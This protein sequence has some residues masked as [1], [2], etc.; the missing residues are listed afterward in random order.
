M[1]MKTGF[2]CMSCRFFLL[3]L[4]GLGFVWLT[5]CCR[6]HHLNHHAIFGAGYRS[7]AVSIMQ[8]LIKKYGQ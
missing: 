6:Y 1:S 7:G 5:E 2:G 4:L 8:R 3:L